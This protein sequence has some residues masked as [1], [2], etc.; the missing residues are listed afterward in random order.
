MSMNRASTP[1]LHRGVAQVVEVALVLLAV[2]DTGEVHHR[3]PGSPPSFQRSI[4]FSCSELNWSAG[5][6]TSCSQYHCTTLA[7]ISEVGVSA[8]YSSI[9]GAPRPS[10]TGR[11]GRTALV[12]SSFQERSISGMNFG[13]AKRS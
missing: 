1:R 7:S 4:S 5:W 3:L 10:Q 11:S 2:G 6:N 13:D 8:L 9:F 12:S